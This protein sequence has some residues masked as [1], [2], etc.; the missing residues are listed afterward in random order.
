[1][2]ALQV[3]GIKSYNRLEKLAS[4][5]KGWD[6]VWNRI[7]SAEPMLATELK[8]WKENYSVQPMQIDQGIVSHL[9]VCNC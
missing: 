8:I 4:N 9:F 1:M 6:I 5:E 7:N 2:T 3:Q